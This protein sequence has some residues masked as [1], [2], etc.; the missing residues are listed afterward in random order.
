MGSKQHGIIIHTQSQSLDQSLIARR[1][2][3]MCYVSYTIFYNPLWTLNWSHVQRQGNNR[4]LR[5]FSSSSMLC[6]PFVSFVV[7]AW[8]NG[9]QRTNEHNTAS[10]FFTSHQHLRTS[11][12]LSSSTNHQSK[13]FVTRLRVYICR[14]NI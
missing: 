5:S 8:G 6:I 2:P 14:Q 7:C 10:I 11:R 13:C 12:A 1:V 3:Q 4:L 9:H